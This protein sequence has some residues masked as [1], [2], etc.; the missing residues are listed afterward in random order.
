MLLRAP[1]LEDNRKPLEGKTKLQDALL[2]AKKS[3]NPGLEVW[4]LLKGKTIIVS[5]DVEALD[6][7]FGKDAEETVRFNIFDYD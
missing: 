4:S 1:F 3:T 2:V 7:P 6:R 5:E